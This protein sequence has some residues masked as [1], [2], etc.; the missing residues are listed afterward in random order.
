MLQA[1]VVPAQAH[2]LLVHALLHRPALPYDVKG[3]PGAQ[4]PSA[5]RAP[6]DLV[7]KEAPRTPHVGLHER[8]VRGTRN[9]SHLGR[10]LLCS[11]DA[12]LLRCMYNERGP[13]AGLK[14]LQTCMHVCA[15]EHLCNC[16]RE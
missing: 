11:L 1:A 10:L 3:A 6:L 2:A 9:G 7:I 15:H 16:A 5:A 8:W 14:C 13:H 4:R 12:R